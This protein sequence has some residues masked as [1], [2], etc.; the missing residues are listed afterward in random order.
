MSLNCY[1]QIPDSCV[2]T[3]IKCS[4]IKTDI[5]IITLS[6]CTCD[7]L[8]LLSVD[9]LKDKKAAIG[10]TYDDSTETGKDEEE[11]ESESEDDIETFDLGMYNITCLNVI[12]MD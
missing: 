6:N 11:E 9:R 8:L 5:W 12:A 7:Q 10:Y 1:E 4:P 2:F 3:Q